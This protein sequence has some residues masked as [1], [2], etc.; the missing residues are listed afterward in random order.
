MPM[1]QVHAF[2]TP[3][4]VLRTA[5]SERGVMLLTL[6]GV[7]QSTFEALLRRLAPDCSVVRGGDLNERLETEVTEYCHGRRREFTLPLDVR[8]TPFYRQVLGAVA[9]IPYGATRTYAEIAAA[10]GKPT[11]VRAVGGA[12]ARNPLPLLIPC[13]RVVATNGLG[14]YG[15]GLELKRRLLTLEGAQ[16]SDVLM[17]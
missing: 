8:V 14:G 13:H 2:L 7:S 16:A 1:V 12:N 9:R 4:G 15:G 10:V 11:A 5:V 6:P 17:K 3:Y